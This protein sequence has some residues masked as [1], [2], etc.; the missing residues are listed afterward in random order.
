MKKEQKIIGSMALTSILLLGLNLRRDLRDLSHE[1]EWVKTEK[2]TLHCSVKS[3]GVIEASRVEK[4]M[5]EVQERVLSKSV[6]EGDVVKKDQVLMELSRVHVKLEYDQKKN[7]L[8]EAQSNYERAV[9]EHRIQVKLFRNNAVPESQVEEAKRATGRAK[10]SL[11][12]ARQEFAIVKRKWDNTIVRSPMD[13]VVLKD[14]LFVGAPVTSNQELIV[15]GDTS[16]FVVRTKVDELD[17]RQIHEGQDVDIV[18]DAYP[19]MDIKGSVKSIA[20]QADREGFAKI[21]VVIDIKDAGGAR[22]KHNLSGQVYILT[23]TIEGGLGVPIKAIQKKIK[24][25]GWVITR[26]VFNFICEREVV[27]GRVAGEKI[28]VISG[29]KVGQSVGIP[30]SREKGS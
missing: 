25:R 19:D 24:E 8:N 5:S 15:V 13:G 16:R 22:L 3:P 7:A 10:A 6:R 23:E 18:V 11:D 1:W 28:E 17:I 14:A 26:N 12:I 2:E 20:S 29:L 30:L 4:I 9:R 27:L 21:E